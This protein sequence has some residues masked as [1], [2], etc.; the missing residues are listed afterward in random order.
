MRP[1]ASRVKATEPIPHG[2]PKLLVTRPEGDVSRL[3][4]IEA[5][6]HTRQLDGLRYRQAENARESGGRTRGRWEERERESNRLCGHGCWRAFVQIRTRCPLTDCSSGRSGVKERRGRRLGTRGKKETSLP[7]PSPSSVRYP[8]PVFQSCLPPI[9]ACPTGGALDPKSHPT[10][11]KG[12]HC[13]LTRKRT[14]HSGRC[15]TLSL[16]LW[17]FH[18]P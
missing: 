4:P 14:A 7:V 15:F 6:V 5:V 8:I 12:N 3:G 16:S 18:S 1:A 11:F 17:R 10:S 13:C 9:L 2:R